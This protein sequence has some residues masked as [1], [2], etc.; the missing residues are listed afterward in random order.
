MTPKQSNNIFR[1]GDGTL[2]SIGILPVRIPCTDPS[3]IAISIDVFTADITILIGLDVLD[4]AKI[5]A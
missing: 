1:F 2:Y 4:S 3:F 5:G